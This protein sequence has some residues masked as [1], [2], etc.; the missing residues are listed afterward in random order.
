MVHFLLIFFGSLMC[1]FILTPV[2]IKAAFKFNILDI[3]NTKNPGKIHTKPTALMGGVGIYLSVVTVTLIVLPISLQVIGL[4]LAMTILLVLGL[5]DDMHNLDY[6]VRLFTQLAVAIMLTAF[7]GFKIEFLAEYPLIAYPLTVFW[8]VGVTNA[9]NLMD[10]VDGATSG[11]SFLAAMGLF[12]FSVING[13]VMVATISLALAGAC[14]GFLYYNFRPASIFLGDTGSLLLGITLASLALLHSGQLTLSSNQIFILPFILGVPIYDTT[15]AT[16]IRLYNKRPI[17]KADK[18]N[19]TYRL[20][21]LGFNQV[22]AVLIEYCMGAFFM[23]SA[24]LLWW[25]TPLHGGFIALAVLAASVLLGIRFAKAP[26]PVP[27]RA[28]TAQQRPMAAEPQFAPA[29]ISE[30]SNIYRKV[31]RVAS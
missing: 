21:G 11:V 22:E 16:S 28:S 1:T 29:R 20:F 30:S 24:L 31:D 5:L 27:T 4:I 6:R 7:F 25:S 19:L 14:L 23:G 15:L 13:D 2:V 26:M 8:I 12:I 18:S 17:Y 10:N 9:L 3:P